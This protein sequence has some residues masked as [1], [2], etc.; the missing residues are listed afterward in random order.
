MTNKNLTNNNG[1]IEM[2][3]YLRSKGIYSEPSV[4]W[5]TF[6]YYRDKVENLEERI[7]YLEYLIA[8]S[9]ISAEVIAS[10]EIDALFCES[11]DIDSGFDWLDEIIKA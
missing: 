7:A 5:G 4:D 10:D 11:V 2:E 8:N 3:D 9:N 1:F 6:K